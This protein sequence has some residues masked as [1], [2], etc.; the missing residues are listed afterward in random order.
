LQAEL[1]N[2]LVQIDENRDT[3]ERAIARRE[4]IEQKKIARKQALINGALA[5]T[6]ALAFGNVAQAVAA[7]I[8]VAAQLITIESQKFER[9]TALSNRLESFIVDSYELGGNASTP[10]IVGSSPGIPSEGMIKGPLHKDGGIPASFNNSAVEVEGGEYKLRNG[11]ETYIINR[12]STKLFRSQLDSLKGNPNKFD[13]AK[14]IAASNINAFR[15][16]GVKFAAGGALGV[17]AVKPIPAPVRLQSVSGSVTREE[18]S[19]AITGVYSGL[20][21]IAIQIDRKTDTIA[22]EIQ[23]ETAAINSRIDRLIVYTDPADI[24]NKGNERIAAQTATE[25]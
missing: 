24:V 20:S 13:P 11:N 25:L 4:A 23:S 5:V 3:Q 22:T 15:G 12:K 21:D 6:R 19:K 9:G 8:A 7:G 10:D 14:R 18:L 1:A 2:K 17:G 16:N